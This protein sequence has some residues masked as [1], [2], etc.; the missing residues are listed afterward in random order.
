MRT[1]PQIPLRNKDH[2]ISSTPNS[3]RQPIPSHDFDHFAFHGSLA[4]PPA[5]SGFIAPNSE[6]VPLCP[7]LLPGRWNP[8]CGV[9]AFED[10]FCVSFEKSPSRENKPFFFGLTSSSSPTSSKHSS[11]MDS[12]FSTLLPCIA[13][14]EVMCEKRESSD[15]REGMVSV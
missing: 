2:P 3:R 13:E 9:E 5:T 14:G 8:R 11:S 4:S 1:Q 7:R 15:V 6:P 10:E 12:G